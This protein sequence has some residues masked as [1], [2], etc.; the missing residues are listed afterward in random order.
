MCGCAA[1]SV[2]VSDGCGKCRLRHSLVSQMHRS[3]VVRVCARVRLMQQDW[4]QLTE[5]TWNDAREARM[6]RG[7]GCV[8]ERET[9]GTEVCGCECGGGGGRTGVVVEQNCGSTFGRL[10]RRRY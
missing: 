1:V 3:Q 8:G 7:R 6:E 4:S 2:P 9:V 10:K 5:S